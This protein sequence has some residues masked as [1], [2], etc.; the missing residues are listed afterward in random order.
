MIQQYYSWVY[1]QKKQNQDLKRYVYS[2]GHWGI[3]HNNL[4]K[5]KVFPGWDRRFHCLIAE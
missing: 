4:E 3:I 5:C 1:I 2:Q